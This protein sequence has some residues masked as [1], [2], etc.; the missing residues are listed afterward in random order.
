MEKSK[1][2]LAILLSVIMIATYMPTI[3]FAAAEDGS[4]NNEGDELITEEPQM[5]LDES[6]EG[7][8]YAAGEEIPTAYSGTWGSLKWG[9]TYDG[10]LIISGIGPM[11]SDNWNGSASSSSYPWRRDH[12]NEIKHVIIEEGVTSIASSAF[13]DSTVESFSIADSVKSID[14]Y[15]F[16]NCDNLT[17]ITVPAS[18]LSFGNNVFSDCIGLTYASLEEGT[19][20][21]GKG[22]FSSCSSLSRVSLPEGLKT[23]QD[24][25]F[26]GCT[27]LT[28]IS[29]PSGLETIK[30]NAFASCSALL[31]VSIP[32]TATY[33]GAGTFS[34]C[35]NLEELYIPASVEE[36]GG[37]LFGESGSNGKNCILKR[38]TVDEKNGNYR[39][40][41]GIVY[42]KSMTKLIECPANIEKDS[43]TVPASV[44]EIGGSA[45]SCNN[46]L[47]S[48]SFE[49]GSQLSTIGVRAFWYADISQISLPEDLVKI[50]DHAFHFCNSLETIVIPDKVTSVG[51]EALRDCKKLKEV[52]F[53]K[54]VETLGDWCCSYCPLQKVVLQ[55][56][57]E[58]I[59]TM[60][61]YGDSASWNVQVYIKA[62]VAPAITDAMLAE[63]RYGSMAFHVP[64][65]SV[66][67]NEGNWKPYKENM[68]YDQDDIYY[69][70]N[71]GR[72]LTEDD[73]Y[74]DYYSF[75]NNKE[76]NKKT[77]RLWGDMNAIN[78]ER[79][80][81]DNE[82]AILISNMK[83]LAASSVINSTISLVTGKYY[84]QDE[85][86]MA[87]ALNYI[88]T[89]SEDEEISAYNISKVKKR[90]KNYKNV[91]TII[92]SG[93]KNK[94]E[95]DML[96]KALESDFWSE[97]EARDVIRSTED[98][99]GEIDSF[100]SAA[101]ETV[102]AA[103]VAATVVIT[104]SANQQLV[105]DLMDVV[106][107]DTALYRGLKSIQ[108]IQNSN[109]GGEIIKR[110]IINHG[111]DEIA[112]FMTKQGI[113]RLSSLIAGTGGIEVGMATAV[114]GLGY[115][116]IGSIADN[117]YANSDEV[118]TSIIAV[119]NQSALM[120]S[121]TD[122]RQKM[123][124]AGSGAPFREEYTLAYKAYLVSL[125]KG[126]DDVLS[127]AKEGKAK[128][129]L[130]ADSAALEDDLTYNRYIKA[131]LK[132]AN[133]DLKYTIVKNN[134]IILGINKADESKRD[135]AQSEKSLRASAIALDADSGDEES[136]SEGLIYVDIPDTIEENEV[137][138]IG[139]KVFEDNNSVLEIY[140]PDS[141]K[142]IDEE[143]FSNCSKLRTVHLGSGIQ[144]IGA[145]AFPDNE[146][147]HIITNDT[148]KIQSVIQNGEYQNAD[149]MVIEEGETE[150]SE[151]RIS[152]NPEK[153]E[154]H[155]SEIAEPDAEDI[156]EGRYT[157]ADLTG[158]ELTAIY[159]DGSEETVTDG[160]LGYFDEKKI[161]ENTITVYYQDKSVSYSVQVDADECPYEISYVD[162]F[163]DDI[164]EKVR[165]TKLA[166]DELTIEVPEISG[167]D[168]L[169][170][171]HT[172]TIAADNNYKVH[173][174]I[175]RKPSIWDAVITLSGNSFKYTGSAIIPSVSV[176]YNEIVLEEGKDYTLSYQDNI[177]PG[178][179]SVVVKGCGDY[180][181]KETVNYVIESPAPS[182]KPVVTPQSSE[183]TDLKSVKM[184]KPKAGKKSVVVKW[185]KLS[186]SKLKKIKKIE[187]QYGLDKNFKTGF[188]STFASAKKTTKKI[189][190]LKKGK[191]YYVRI[192]AYT[193][194]GGVVHVS[195]WTKAK[196]FKV[197]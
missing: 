188:K 136:D 15:A 47:K 6:D 45:F 137:T 170:E 186:K 36:L 167:Y 110:L 30:G 21:V 129:K 3:A 91:N 5:T 160:F 44:K 13:M 106:D 172:V 4:D 37:A 58:S 166:G 155:M 8:M 140:V 134:A 18:V 130:E 20:E 114:A 17:E 135:S 67:Y 153:L 197:K 156:S 125:K 79:T 73:L 88:Q 80:K 115:W 22:M 63:R 173:Y 102:N 24:A 52:Y 65:H 68:R 35:K 78:A 109:K 70:T 191:K 127:A 157:A 89:L 16:R 60:S 57:I 98:N 50:S 33:I 87:V 101:G 177:A 104:A 43:F 187:I 120:C 176:V 95:R 169:D 86:E 159:S 9:L 149:S 59:G 138:G 85:L 72:K 162:S 190:K 32:S 51:Y 94:E 143:A 42:N 192:R 121:V 34:G 133:K 55:E 82:G 139:S 196:S 56:N 39:S 181:G 23:I 75:L 163:G 124:E 141:V 77:E 92:K 84:N 161:G 113:G 182:V 1:R 26:S 132:E 131:C 158:L 66:G 19:V 25:A 195:K 144:T 38:I 105:S 61:F 49:S 28:E 97:E 126:V 168:P 69:H 179:A 178:T 142:T 171:P 183:I 76:Y 99:W 31:S 64:V 175:H 107:P 48:I 164:A 119:S 81:R 184:L 103:E 14:T 151:I 154:Y 193:K 117:F 108:D 148:D 93:I 150:L 83:Q 194:S 100:F 180:V 12:N 128:E 122:F 2:L 118:V 62:M 112:S 185:K 152:K 146:G 29:L 71:S 123:I 41:D 145:K 46:T 53:G 147:L 27:S 111:F 90:L 54:N 165:G 7:L 74:G 96:A 10:D 174:S 189:S 116:V 40:V 11:K